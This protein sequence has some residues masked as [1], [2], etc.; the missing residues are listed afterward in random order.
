MAK[1]GLNNF[2]YGLLTENPDGTASYAGTHKPAKA[3]SCSVSITSNSA[4]L[5]ADDV[6]DDEYGSAPYTPKV[7]A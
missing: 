2:R 5:Y 6:L 1:I 4:T 7:Y 3:V